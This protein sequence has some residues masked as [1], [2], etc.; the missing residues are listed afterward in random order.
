MF[1]GCGP[2]RRTAEAEVRVLLSHEFLWIISS[3]GGFLCC[4]Q[5]FYALLG[6]LG[7]LF[8]SSWAIY[9]KGPEG[10]SARYW[11][12]LC[13]SDYVL[14][15]EYNLR[16]ITPFFPPHKAE[17]FTNEGATWVTSLVVQ[18]LRPELPVQGAWVRSLLTEL[19]PAWHTWEF[20]C[21]S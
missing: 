15:P 17:T 16:I 13:C 11:C 21:C 5:I 12:V 8:L 14:Q 7:T 2:G 6:S 4:H 19:D 1:I 18:W 10:T 9:N 20:A 3:C